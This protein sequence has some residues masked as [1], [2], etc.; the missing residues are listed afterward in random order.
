MSPQRSAD[1]GDECG[2]DEGAPAQLRNV[3]AEGRRGDLVLP[4]GAQQLA[5]PRFL[6]ASATT[7]TMAATIAATGMSVVFGRPKSV[8]GP[9]VK[10]LQL[11]MTV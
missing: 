11:F 8:R 9:L 6:K 2:K 7:T 4:R 3:G 10:A 1:A 5:C